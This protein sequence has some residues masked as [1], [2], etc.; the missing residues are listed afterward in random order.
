MENARTVGAVVAGVVDDEVRV[1]V[2]ADGENVPSSI[3]L[4]CWLFVVVGDK[5]RSFASPAAQKAPHRA[6]PRADDGPGTN[7]DPQVGL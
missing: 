6:Q 3:L 1:A 7:M 2:V 4:V 5:S